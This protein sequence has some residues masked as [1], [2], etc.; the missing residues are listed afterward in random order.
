MFFLKRKLRQHEKLAMKRRHAAS[1]AVIMI[2]QPGFRNRQI[3]NGARTPTYPDQRIIKTI[4]V[5]ALLESKRTSLVPRNTQEVKN[6][7]EYKLCTEN[8]AT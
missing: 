8:A 2:T 1:N 3:R 5:Y 6:K 4:V 7:R